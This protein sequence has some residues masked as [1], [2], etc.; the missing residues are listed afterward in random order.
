MTT[1]NPKHKSKDQLDTIKN[2]KNL[3]YSRQKVINLFNDCAKIMSEAAHKTKS[4]TGRK[5]L[6]PK[7]ML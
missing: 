2:I 3:Y 5:I 1:G 7:Q 6:T 4:G